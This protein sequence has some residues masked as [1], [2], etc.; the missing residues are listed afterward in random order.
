MID[1]VIV[2]DK[3]GQDAG[4]L[5]LWRKAQILK[6][7]KF[8]LVNYHAVPKKQQPETE[9]KYFK[10]LPAQYRDKNLIFLGDF[11]VPQKHSVL[12]PLRKLGYMPAF[13]GQK[14]SLRTKCINGD[15][16][17][18][19]YDNFWVAKNK[20]RLTRMSAILFHK[21]IGTLKDAR[22]ISDHIPIAITFELL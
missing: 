9:I 17:A 6:Q 14:T 8:T 12:N 13:V 22:K 10:L 15:C 20:V 19:E 18:S 3:R 1:E 11:N 5:G 16:L 21:S 2:D 7:K 4:I